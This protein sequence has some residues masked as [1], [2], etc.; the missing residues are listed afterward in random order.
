MGSKTM[1][2]HLEHVGSWNI[3]A[4]LNAPEAHH[5]PIEPLSDQGRS[6]FDRRPSDLLWRVL[7]AGDA[8]F[9]GA[10]LELAFPT[11]ITDGA[12]QWMIDQK[13]FQRFQAHLFQAIRTRADNHSIDDRR[14]TGS[15]RQFRTFHLNQTD[16]AGFEQA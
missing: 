8:E 2:R 15:H 3:D 5:T 12:V 11:G 9:V 6:I 10:I 4:G 16:A 14:R 1:F 13:K 7:V